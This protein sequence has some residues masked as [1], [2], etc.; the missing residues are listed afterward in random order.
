MCSQAHALIRSPSKRSLGTRL[1]PERFGRPQAAL[2]GT[3]AGRG[4]AHRRGSLTLDARAARAAFATPLGSPVANGS[5][6]ERSCAL[7]PPLFGA[8]G[9]FMHSCCRRAHRPTGRLTAIGGRVATY[10]PLWPEIALG[11]SPGS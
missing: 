9:A 2:S 4:S 10:W 3:T 7:L 11:N 6:L 1:L 5:M 8:E